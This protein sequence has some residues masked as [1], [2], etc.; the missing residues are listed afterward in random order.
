MTEHLGHDQHE[1]VTN[2]AGNA[3]DD[4]SGKTLKG[5]FGEIALVIP[6]NRHVAFEPQWVAKQ[7][8]HGSGFSVYLK[9]CVQRCHVH[10][11]RNSLNFVTRK[12]RQE[13]AADGQLIDTSASNELA[14]QRRT[15]FAA[16]W[17]A[18]NWARITP[19]L[20]YPPAIC[21][22]INTPNAREAFN[23]SL[24]KVG[25]TRALFSGDEAVSKWVYR[26]LNNLKKKQC[27]S[28]SG[29]QH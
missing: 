6:R 20:A 5:D 14:A 26:A 4:H 2:A 7:Q 22:V 29:I 27:R 15:D 9:A 18:Q 19:F 21:R 10:S 24:R 25:K 17:A 11:V 3:R 28:G 12:A 13:V 8:T 23:R 16:K 1:A